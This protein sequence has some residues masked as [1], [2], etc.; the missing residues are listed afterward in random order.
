MEEYVMD[1]TDKV[2]QAEIMINIGMIIA[3]ISL[4]ICY[5]SGLLHGFFVNNEFFFRI[6]FTVLGVVSMIIGSSIYNT[7]DTELN[8]GDRLWLI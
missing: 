4:L 1:Y 5:I 3:I 2:D 8:Q 6:S 7:I